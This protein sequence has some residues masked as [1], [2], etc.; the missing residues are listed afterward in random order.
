MPFCMTMEKCLEIHLRDYN[1]KLCADVTILNDHTFIFKNIIMDSG[2]EDG[3]ASDAHRV[4]PGY[5][6]TGQLIRF[7]PSNL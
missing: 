1:Y 2:N 4:F 6:L 5:I 7:C 3:A